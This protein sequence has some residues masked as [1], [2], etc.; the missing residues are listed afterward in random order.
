MYDII[1][2]ILLMN[3]LSLFFEILIGLGTSMRGS[4]FFVNSVQMLYY[5]CHKVNFK[6]GGSYIDFPDWT[7]KNCTQK[8]S[9]ISF[10]SKFNR[11]R[12]KYPSK[13]DDWK[14]FEKN[15][16]MI[17]LNV[18][19]IKERVICHAYISKINSDCE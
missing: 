6:S 5:K 11:D 4:Y 13:I 15:N 18:L 9:N 16:L 3:F 7:K 19:Y 14:T 2:M 1:Q 10:I 12:I 8:V 17:A